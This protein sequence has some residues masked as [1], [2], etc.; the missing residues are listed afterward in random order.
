MHNL[1]SHIQFRTVP[2][3]ESGFSGPSIPFICVTQQVECCFVWKY[4]SVAVGIVSV[5]GEIPARAVISSLH[6]PNDLNI[7]RI[8]MKYFCTTLC[9]GLQI[10]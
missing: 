1:T 10:N 9:I 5:N 3:L 2:F 8:Q 4:R 7:V 6:T